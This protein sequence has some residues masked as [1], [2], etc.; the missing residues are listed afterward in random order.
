LTRFGGCLWGSRGWA[1]ENN[2]G[3]L[4]ET[5][6]HAKTYYAQITVIRP[7]IQVKNVYILAA[8][9]LV[10]DITSPYLAQSLLEVHRLRTSFRC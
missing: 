3:R 8:C 10:T 9:Y 1:L 2:T 7:A 5:V 6:D 4:E